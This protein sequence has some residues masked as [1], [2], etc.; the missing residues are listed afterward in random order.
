M[1]RN[2]RIKISGFTLL[3]I[4]VALFIFTILSLLL[5]GGL[6]SVIQAQSITSQSAERLHQLQVTLL[7]MS[8]DI[9]Q[10]I[11]RPIIVSSGRNEK[12]FIGT[13]RMFSFTHVGLANPENIVRS[14]MQHTQY[15]FDQGALWRTTW[16]VVDQAPQSRA[17]SRQLLAATHVS[18]QYLDKQ[19]HFYNHWPKE[20]DSI[21][22]PLPKAIRIYFKLPSWGEMSQLYVIPQ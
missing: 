13:Y 9:E 8:R 5:A 17:H 19:G 11:N 10:A 22:E 15:R 16:P 21:R 6:H 14:S 2:N 12:A 20:V 4:L 7:L 18:F 3:E 1:G